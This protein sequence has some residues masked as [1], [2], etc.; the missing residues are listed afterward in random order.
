MWAKGRARQG[1]RSATGLLSATQ[2]CALALVLSLVLSSSAFFLPDNAL[3]GLIALDLLLVIHGLYLKNN[4]SALLKLGLAQLALTLPLYYL[5]HGEAKLFEGVIVVLRV[6]LAMLPGW[7]LSSTQ[8][9][10]RLGEVLSWGLP[11][12]WAFV[13]AASIGLL[14]YMLQE[15]KEIYA[16]QCLRGA[17]ITPKALRNPKNWPELVYC[18][19]LPV[20]IQLLKLSKQMAKAAKLRHF[21]KVNKPTHWPSTREDK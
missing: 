11:A 4:I 9:P 18:V 1:V 20:L 2:Y 8:S 21:G 3:A 16:I 10:E 5:L 7:W 13:I 19:L 12:K 14:P 15:T 17:N 6:F